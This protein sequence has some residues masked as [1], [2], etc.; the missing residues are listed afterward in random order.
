MLKVFYYLR[1]K[2]RGRQLDAALFPPKGVKAFYP[3]VKHEEGKPVKRDNLLTKLVKFFPFALNVKDMPKVDA[4]LLY[5]YGCLLKGNKP[6]V[7]EVDN[8]AC[9][10]YYSPVA[11]K[12]PL[13]KSI[14]KSYIRNENFV[15]FLPMSKAAEKGLVNAFGEEVKEKS[16]VVYPPFPYKV[17]PKSNDVLSFIFISYH[18][19]AKGGKELLK[20]V[21]KLE[22]K[23]KLTI[24][25]KMPKMKLPNNVE[26]K[27]RVLRDELINSILPSYDV[28]VHPSY[29]D[30]FGIAPYEAINIGLAGISTNLYALPEFIVH[31]RNGFNFEPPIKYFNDDFLPN[32]RFW[33]TNIEEF[34]KHHEFPNVVKRLVEYMQYYIDNPKELRKHKRYSKKLAKERFS[35]EIRNKVLLDVFK[36]A[37]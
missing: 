25:G 19:Y 31:E 24:V 23:F 16:Q 22:G 21:K 20:A 37:V 17:K 12:N 26:F 4:D 9:L 27:G 36:R 34:A 14:I 5:A 7:T 8:P 3:E 33:Y 11:L 35:L 13:I 6:Y 15:S 10:T 32:M 1:G 29:W 28:I 18:F 30:S 2:P